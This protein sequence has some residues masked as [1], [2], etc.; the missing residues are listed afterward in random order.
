MGCPCEIGLYSQSRDQ[1]RSAFRAAEKE[2]RRL[3]RKYSHYR[4][5]SYLSKINHQAA[6][7]DGIEVDDE[8]AGLLDYAEVQYQSS[9]GL[10][11]ITAGAL[12]A[13]WD[14]INVLPQ[15][16]LLAVA[17]SRTGWHQVC[18]DGKTLRMPA[19]MKIDPG[20][21]VKEYAADRAALELKTRGIRSAFV[22]LGGDLHFLGPHPDGRPWQTG[23]RNPNGE[24]NAVAT[25]EVCSGGL[26]SSGDYERYSKIGDKQYGHIINPKT[27]WP[28]NAHGDALLSASALA[29]SCLL[30]G[31]ITTLA[32]LAGSDAGLSFLE[33]SGV[34]WLAVRPDSRISGTIQAVA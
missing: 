6:S 23:I 21:L 28:A 2:V 4:G 32:L 34:P 15:K 11:D 14:R 1:A 30:A 33:D 10:F 17:L 16:H 25:I 29:P 5:D 26:A 9:E 7:P 3:D 13:I 22:D 12:S 20:G 27:G 18:W 24:A 8:T 19:G 31:S